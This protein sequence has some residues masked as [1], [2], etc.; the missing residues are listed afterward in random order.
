MFAAAKKSAASEPGADAIVG[1]PLVAASAAGPVD[2]EASVS[3]C[4]NNA[5][6]DDEKVGEVAPATNKMPYSA[7]GVD[8]PLL[9]ASAVGPVDIE[10]NVSNCTNSSNFD[11]KRVDGVASST[12]QPPE[13]SSA[14]APCGLAT[15]DSDDFVLVDYD[16]GS[17]DT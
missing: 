16:E 5:T 9:A 11:H 14:D 7:A 2:G 6:F 13:S 10:T 4:T 1:S 3:I 15:A 8:S 17:D 12:Y